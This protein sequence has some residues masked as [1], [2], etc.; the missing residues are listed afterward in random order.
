[1]SFWKAN[2]PLKSRYLV[3]LLFATLFIAPHPLFSQATT[4]GQNKVEYRDF[5]WSYLQSAH[6]DVYFT[7]GGDYLATYAADVA[8]SSYAAISKSFR[9][10]IN[11]RIPIVVYN[12]HNDFQQTNVVG[13]Y[14]E[15]GIGGVTEM[16]K[17]RVVL[18][19][20]GDYAKFRHVIHH[21]LTH[22]VVNDMFYGGSLQSIITNNITLQLPLWFN[23]G[24][25]E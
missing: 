20:E 17:N 8:E 14:L 13:E 21:E 19:F 16:F 23:E 25:A 22:A 4:F 2:L 6:F 3:P 1:M 5:E 7:N 11:N 18:P 24:L 15:E 9:Y 10:Q 12:S